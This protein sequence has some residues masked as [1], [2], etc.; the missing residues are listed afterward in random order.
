M[1][2]LDVATLFAVFSEML[3]AATWPLVV[4]ALLATAK[5]FYVLVRDDALVPRRLVCA[6]LSGLAGG[7]LAVL[8]MLSVTSSR[9]SDFGGAIDLLLAI[10]IF[11]AG[12]VGTTVCVYALLG[13][14][15]RRA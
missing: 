11:A 12:A 3:G 5:F 4:G 13:S 2:S 8:L 6:Q 14:F 9:F 15:R 7:V 10:G 1:N